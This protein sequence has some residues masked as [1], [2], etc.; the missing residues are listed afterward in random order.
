MTTATITNTNTAINLATSSRV[1]PTGR[2]SKTAEHA[3]LASPAMLSTR[4]DGNRDREEQ[5]QNDGKRSDRE[6]RR[7]ARA[8]RIGRPVL[9]GSRADLRDRQQVSPRLVG[10]RF[11]KLMAT[12]VART[13]REL[14]QLDRRSCRVHPITARAGSLKDD[15]LEA[16]S[17][18]RELS[19]WRCPG[20][21]AP[22]LTWPDRR[23]GR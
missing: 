12:Q 7:P 14:A 10:N 13:T 19:D 5:R 2:A 1:R 8:Q 18:S 9:P 23:H 17:F 16:V 3:A 11:S 20:P 6:Q 15:L 4:D 22:A 21:L